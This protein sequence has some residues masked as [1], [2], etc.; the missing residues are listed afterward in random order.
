MRELRQADQR[1]LDIKETADAK[2]LVL[3]SENQRLR[4]E[5]HNGLLNQL[6]DERA[7]YATKAEVEAGFDKLEAKIDA[8]SSNAWTRT[9]AATAVVATIAVGLIVGLH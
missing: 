2:A 9:L 4:D 5:A 7:T 1:A 8:G 6:R 3:A